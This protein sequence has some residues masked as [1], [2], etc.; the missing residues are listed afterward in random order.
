MT[1]VVLSD[2]EFA[3]IASLLHDAAGLTFDESRRDSLTFS[4][5]ERMSIT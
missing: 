5:A 2:Y 1:R 4:V 3:S